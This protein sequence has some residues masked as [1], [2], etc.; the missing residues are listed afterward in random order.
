MRFYVT[1][2]DHDQASVEAVA[3]NVLCVL[4]GNSEITP[5]LVFS[6]AVN[7]NG[8][9]PLVHSP[10]FPVND[11]TVIPPIV[12]KNLDGITLGGVIVM[13]PDPPPTGDAIGFDVMV[14]MPPVRTMFRRISGL[15]FQ[16]AHA[17]VTKNVSV[18]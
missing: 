15:A 11:G 6:C 5:L 2:Q 4:V 12:G 9:P 7:G 16:A 18:S 3:L 1:L 8:L 17:Q 10:T 14:T 13:A